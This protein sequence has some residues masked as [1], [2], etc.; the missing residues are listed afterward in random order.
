M[1]LSQFFIL[2]VLPELTLKAAQTM[3]Q[4]TLEK[5]RPRPG[6]PAA[7]PQQCEKTL[8]VFVVP[9]D[10]LPPIPAAKQ[11]IH[12][13]FKFDTKLSRH[14]LSLA[15]RIPPCRSKIV[16][17]GTD[18]YSL[19]VSDHTPS[20]CFAIGC[21][22]QSLNSPATDTLCAS[23]FSSRNSCGTACAGIAMI[24]SALTARKTMTRNR[25]RVP[26]VSSQTRTGSTPPVY[27]PLIVA[28]TSVIAAAEAPFYSVNVSV[29]E[30]L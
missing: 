17:G 5:G 27:L 18:P 9:K 3:Y 15:S 10:V 20:L 21:A 24:A 29:D 22:C 1:K 2:T 6:A 8:L 26:A 28:S 19:S 12:C 13:S 11:V 4:L 30:K 14:S 25:I 23:L 16:K 7:A